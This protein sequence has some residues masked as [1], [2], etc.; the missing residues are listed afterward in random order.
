MASACD[1]AVNRLGRLVRPRST[2]RFVG[3]LVCALLFGLVGMHGLGPVPA[4]PGHDPMP[5]AAPMSVVASMPDA[6]DHGEGGCTG[7]AQH[8]DPTCA[9][10]AVAGSPAMVPVLLPDV[11]AFAGVP[12]TGSAP[13]GSGPDG[14]RAPPSLSELQ[15]LRI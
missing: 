4:G 14:G 11:A 13:T 1:E 15:L 10:A 12:R 3:L 9:S 2:S 7:H 8:A 5:M 6:C